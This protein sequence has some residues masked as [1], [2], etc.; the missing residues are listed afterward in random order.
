MIN[1]V[2]TLIKCGGARVVLC[3]YLGYA[4]ML[5]PNIFHVLHI[6]TLAA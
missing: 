3:L 1:E 4:S 5:L 2:T 6:V